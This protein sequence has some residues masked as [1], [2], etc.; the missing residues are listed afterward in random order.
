MGLNG[1][2]YILLTDDS[3]KA[4]VLKLHF[5]SKFSVKKTDVQAGKAELVLVRGNE[6]V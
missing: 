3:Q 2:N 5:T 6:A 4:E 1:T